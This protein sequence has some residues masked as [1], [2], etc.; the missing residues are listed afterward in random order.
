MCPRFTL[1]LVVSVVDL[2]RLSRQIKSALEFLNV[3]F[4]RANFLLSPNP[5]TFQENKVIFGKQFI[6]DKVKPY[7]NAKAKYSI[8]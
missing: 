2:I 6:K 5:R 4:T 8:R 1:V 7:L 3:S